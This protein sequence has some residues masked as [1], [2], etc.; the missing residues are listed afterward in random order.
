[1]YLKSKVMRFLIMIFS[2]AM[3]AACVSNAQTSTLKSTA[4]GLNMMLGDPSK[5]ALLEEMRFEH[6]KD[7]SINVIRFDHIGPNLYPLIISSRLPVA[8]DS[9]GILSFTLQKDTLHNFLEMIDN[10]NPKMHSRKF[11]KVL[12]RVTYRFE[13][14]AD[15][16]YVTNP[17]VTTEFLKLIEKKLI[18]NKDQMA[19]EKFYE[20]IAE[21]GL[22]IGIHGKRTW[23]Y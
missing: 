2:L 5:E 12:I 17:I 22:Q 9:L 7:S 3:L 19:L 4:H 6:G 10:V 1:M 18:N 20:F 13:G 23:K 8:T 11:D 14:K 16:Y 15:L 21:T